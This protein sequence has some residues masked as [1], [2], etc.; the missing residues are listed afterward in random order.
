MRRRTAEHRLATELLRTHY[1]RHYGYPLS[2]TTHVRPGKMY[3]ILEDWRTA[4]YLTDGW[5]PETVTHYRRRYY[6]VSRD[7]WEQLPRIVSMIDAVHHLN[8]GTAT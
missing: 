7:G 3:P 1:A 2:R 8:R 5:E 6:E 4:G